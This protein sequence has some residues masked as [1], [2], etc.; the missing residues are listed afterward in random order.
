MKDSTRDTYQCRINGL[1]R[2]MRVKDNTRPL[3]DWGDIDYFKTYLNLYKSPTR[4]QVL[5]AL[6]VLKPSSYDIVFKEMRDGIDIDPD[7]KWTQK[8]KEQLITADDLNQKYNE[9]LGRY[10]ESH[11]LEDFVCVFYLYPFHDPQIEVLRNDLATIRI[12]EVDETNYYNG[13]LIVLRHHKSDKKGVLIY[14]VPRELRMLLD[15]WIEERGLSY[16]DYLYPHSKSH[17]GRVLRG[18]LGIG[19]QMLRKIWATEYRSEDHKEYEKMT[20]KMNEKA[21][22]MG[23]TLATEKKYYIKK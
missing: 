13:D 10:R 6:I 17:V 7:G 18:K 15:E 12:G 3:E 20:K 21:R 5:N 22:R 19:V 16:G 9:V 1:A 11:K 8:E 2:R 23:H 14:D 4:R